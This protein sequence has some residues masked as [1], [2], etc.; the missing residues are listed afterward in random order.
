MAKPNR[1]PANDTTPLVHGAAT[2]PSVMLDDYNNEAKDK[3]GFIGDAANKKNFRLKLDNQRKLLRDFGRDPF[4][5]VPT[6]ELKKKEIDALLRGDDLLAAAAVQGAIEEFSHGFADVIRKFLNEKP[7]KKTERIAVGGGFR[8]RRMGELVI[9][10]TMLLLRENG[11]DIELVPIA[12]HPDDAG[13]IGS[14]HLMPEWMLKGHD[15]ILA[16]DIGGTNVR[17]GVVGF[18]KNKGK[19]VSDASVKFSLIWRHA[20]ERP[21]RTSTVAKI[22]ELLNEMIMKAG[23]AKLS[24]APLIGIGCPGVI[25]ADGA[26]ARGGQN[27]PGGNWES[28]HFNLPAALMKS[29]P[30]INDA[31]TFII[32]HNDGVVQG[33]SQ[34][35]LMTDKK[36]WAILTIGTGLGNA[37][38]TNRSD[39]DPIPPLK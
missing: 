3:K 14:V 39:A 2:L 36:D 7:W 35:P 13:L 26:I 19:H 28:D 17:V 31:D 27:L 34:I 20:D 23:E 6:K 22:S 30:Q 15:A 10:R 18:G 38:F 21:G 25:E 24:L 11:I 29:I 32:M 33:L 4:G 5:D 16:V 9:A 8:H 12:H 1:T 37:H